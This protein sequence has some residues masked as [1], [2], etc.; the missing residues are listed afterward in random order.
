MF[1]F[2]LPKDDVIFDKFKE[3]SILLVQ[4]AHRLKSMVDEGGSYETHARE[5]K[6][7][8]RRSDTLVHATLQHLF[9]TF[10]TPF[11]RQD[12]L[13]LTKKLDDIL[14]L[15]EGT[16][17]RIE[18]YRPKQMMQEARDLAGILVI[19]VERI[20]KMMGLLNRMKKNSN[21]ISDLA[22]DVH[23]FET[24]ADDKRR[25]GIAHLFRE[26]EDAK[27]VIKVRSILEHI[28]RATDA[29]ARV[30]DIIEGIIIENS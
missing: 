2:F 3:I 12:I 14:D 20:D 13:R 1:R 18:L 4:A 9:K 6:A 5:I 22:V 16:S 24:E 26:E 15:T 27:E 7:L 10:I 29:C 25:Q 11:D 21:E 8:E 28:E 23:H 19:C 17:T 30:A